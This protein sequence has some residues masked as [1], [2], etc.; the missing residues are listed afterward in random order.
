MDFVNLLNNNNRFWVK[1]A[2]LEPGNVDFPFS[3]GFPVLSVGPS[4]FLAASQVAA[5]T[6]H[7]IPDNLVATV[8]I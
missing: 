2:S 6:F 4:F 5:A 1:L 7:H 3:S 8:M